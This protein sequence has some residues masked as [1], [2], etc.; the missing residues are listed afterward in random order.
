M[1]RVLDE[2]AAWS[3]AFDGRQESSDGRQLLRAM[4]LAELELRAGTVYLLRE[5][6]HPFEVRYVGETM[7]PLR[8]R[9]AGHRSKRELPV[10]RWIATLKR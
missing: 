4:R 8:V 1:A 7:T 3:E 2:A 6:V 5:P 9:L 10:G